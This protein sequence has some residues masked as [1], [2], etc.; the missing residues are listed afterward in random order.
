MSGTSILMFHRVTEPTPRAFGLPDAWRVRGTA[1]SFSELVAMVGERP[2]LP[3]AAVVEAI[4]QGQD[5]PP[6]VVLTFDD[7]YAEWAQVGADLA[8]RGWPA[9]FFW[10]RAMH[11]DGP[12][13][14][15]DEYYSLLDR[16]THRTFEIE[17]PNGHRIRGDLSDHTG[18][19]ALVTDGPKPFIIDPRTAPTMLDSVAAAVGA[20]RRTNEAREL[21]L[22]DDQRQVLASL[23][24]EFG[25]HGLQHVRLSSLDDEALET[26]IS[27]S[28]RWL[29]EATTRW[30]AYPDG[31]LDTRVV[32]AVRAAGYRAALTCKPAYVGRGQDLLRLPRLFALGAR[33]HC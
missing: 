27:G 26:E 8:E 33:R 2:V 13:H 18:K 20:P 14:P 3:L 4:E 30:F 6:G 24:H 5:P 32:A 23:G 22:D 25:A 28:R 1:L 31:D 19:L 15:V 7:G 11:A 10:S 16:A 9:T 21:Y 29:G 12:I 17:L